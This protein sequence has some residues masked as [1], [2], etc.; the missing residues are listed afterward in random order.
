MYLQWQLK[1]KRKKV[2]NKSKGYKLRT[3]TF[4]ERKQCR[5]LI[6]ASE[7]TTQGA[8]FD[9]RQ[10]PHQTMQSCKFLCN[11]YKQINLYMLV[12]I[13]VL[14]PN[15][16]KPTKINPKFFLTL[17]RNQTIKINNKNLQN[18]NTKIHSLMLLKQ[19]K[20]II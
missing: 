11:K 13:N 16:Q 2:W 7:K 20:V 14:S 12:V 19:T 18:G 6:A 17:M 15:D 8:V 10:F 3:I 1:K 5:W 4:F 9:R